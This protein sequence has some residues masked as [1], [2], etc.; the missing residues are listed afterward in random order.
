MSDVSDV[1]DTIDDETVITI[2]YAPR[3]LQA[4]FHD[5]FAAQ[6]PRASCLVC[7]R[8]FGKSVMTVNELI[9]GLMTSPHES[10]RFAFIAPYLKQAKDIA[11]DYVHRFTAP[12][13]GVE[14]NESELRVDLPGDR[15]LRLYGADNPDSIQGIYLDGVVMDEYQLT[16]P[17]LFGQIVRPMLADRQGWVIFSG[18]PLGRN[19]FYDLYRAMESDPRRLTRL[20][21]ASETGILSNEELHDMRYGPP[22]MTTDEY[23]QE[24]E[25]SWEAAIQGAYY[26][27]EMEACRADG[28]IKPL[29]WEP[30]LP[31]DTY[32]D[33]GFSDAT[34]IVFAQ[35]VGR[36]I[37][38]L[39]YLEASGQGLAYYVRELNQRP[40]L[41]GHHYLPHDAG[42]AQQGLEGRTLA[43]QAKALGLRPITVLGQ[44]DVM[45]GINQAR[46]IFPR[47]WFDSRKAD[48]LVEV[49]A[50][51]RCQWDDKKQSFRPEPLHD[52][53]S[54]GADAFRYMAVS[55]RDFSGPRSTAPRAA[56]RIDFDPR[57]MERVTPRDPS[58]VD[59]SP[60]RGRW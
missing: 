60:F 55:L 20:Y 44:T 22:A 29:T 13:P 53:A 31:V 25:C 15:R 32:W 40:Y 43:D 28:R 35:R 27:R 21:R 11:W 2:P 14:Y 9:R 3:A 37:H 39:D 48:R 10:P 18:K 33:L 30:P 42:H 36:E 45:A 46:L 56:S 7:H 41:Y 50:Q 47:C 23:A 24:L 49:L 38:V 57:R 5:A 52:W 12:I 51:Y 17:R 1:S 4:E 8:R 16:S 6:R 58:K 26:A 34:A 54:H 19:H 59:F